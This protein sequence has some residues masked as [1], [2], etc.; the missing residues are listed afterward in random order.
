MRS[1]HIVLSTHSIDVQ[2]QEAICAITSFHPTCVAPNKQKHNCSVWLLI[3][4]LN[5]INKIW[6]SKHKV[7]FPKRNTKYQLNIMH[8]TLSCLN[9]TVHIL[10]KKRY[11]LPCKL[12]SRYVP[13]SPNNRWATKG[14]YDVLESMYSTFSI[15]NNKVI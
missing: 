9:M 4:K 2:N 13:V 1:L 3:A 14:T 10:N 7:Y 11:W 6:T 15:F 5:Q 12:Q 8:Y